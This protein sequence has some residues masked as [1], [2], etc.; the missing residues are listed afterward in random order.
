MKGL[1][2]SS[3]EIRAMPAPKTEGGRRSCALPYLAKTADGGMPI[4]VFDPLL[5][6][7]RRR[8]HVTIAQVQ[9]SQSRTMCYRDEEC[10]EVV[11][12]HQDV[13]EDLSHVSDDV[14]LGMPRGRTTVDGAHQRVQDREP[15]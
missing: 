7:R 4:L 11:L 14:A 5:G 8:C 2:G 6:S 13:V 15:S 10:T 12:L 3:C 1:G 9:T